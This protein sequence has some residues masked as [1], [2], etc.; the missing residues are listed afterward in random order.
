MSVKASDAD[1]VYQDALVQLKIISH[2]RFVP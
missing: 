1:F 2:R